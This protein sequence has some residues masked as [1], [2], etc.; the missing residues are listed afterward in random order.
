[1][2]V[3]GQGETLVDS[4]LRIVEKHKIKI[5]YD[6]CRSRSWCMKKTQRLRGG[7]NEQK[8]S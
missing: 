1:M 8:Q 2:E 6:S 5:Q 7:G 4:L 3:A